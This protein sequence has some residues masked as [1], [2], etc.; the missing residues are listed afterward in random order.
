M[1]LAGFR[2]TSMIQRGTIGSPDADR[3]SAAGRRR[4]AIMTVTT[5]V[6]AV[7]A[8]VVGNPHSLGATDERIRPIQLAAWIK[9]QRPGLRVVDLRSPAAFDD[10]HLPT[11]EQRSIQALETWPRSADQSW[12]STAT[13]MSGRLRP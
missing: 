11:A 5:L 6:L 13:M 10:Y 2:L 9:D 1:A 7:G 3:A 12:S 4:T 8:A